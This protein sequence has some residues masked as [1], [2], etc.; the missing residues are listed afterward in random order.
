MNSAIQERDSA[1]RVARALYEEVRRARQLEE[2]LDI[3]I[4]PGEA[5]PG[6]GNSS[7]DLAWT[8]FMQASAKSRAVLAEE[9]RAEE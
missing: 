7:F 5:A 2:K 3:L 9:A 4:R 1:R 8:L 6:H